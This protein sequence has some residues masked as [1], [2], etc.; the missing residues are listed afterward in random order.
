MASFTTRVEL[1]SAS[2]EDYERLHSYMQ[3]EQFSRLIKS[4]DGTWYHL[5]T[6]EY[7][8]SGNYSAADT[9]A[10]A[11]RAAA[12]TSK[13]YSVLVTETNRRTWFNL[14]TA[15]TQKAAGYR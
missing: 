2:A 7:D 5:P 1:H 10:A 3:A 9:L 15:V 14:P 12:R 4:D 11:K 8:R 6:A 13:N